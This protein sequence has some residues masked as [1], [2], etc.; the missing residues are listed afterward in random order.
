MEVN[1]GGIVDTFGLETGERR[2]DRFAHRV[3]AVVLAVDRAFAF[4]LAACASR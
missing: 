2:P 4:R 1:E 3:P